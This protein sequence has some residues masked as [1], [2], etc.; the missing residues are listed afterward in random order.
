MRL[1]FGD[2]KTEMSDG[3]QSRFQQWRTMLQSYSHCIE[4][5]RGDY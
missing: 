2:T 5:K 4:S 1:T 3:I